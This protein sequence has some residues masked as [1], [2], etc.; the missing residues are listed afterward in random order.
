MTYENVVS[1]CERN[2]PQEEYDSFADWYDECYN[3]VNTPN[4]FDNPD[5]NRMMEDSWLGAFGTYERNPIEI[6]TS[7]QTTLPTNIPERKELPK[8]EERKIPQT[9]QAPTIPKPQLVFPEVQKKE[10]RF[11]TFKRALRG[12]FKR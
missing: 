6:E 12:L 10:S 11:Q 8:E 5:F 7:G 9:G 4:L 1:W 3:K 2:I